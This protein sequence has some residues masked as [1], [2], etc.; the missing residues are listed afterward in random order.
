MVELIVLGLVIFTLLGFIAWREVFNK[1]VV[2]NLTDKLMARDFTE[3]RT[4]TQDFKT[5]KENK[6]EDGN[7][8]PVLDPVLGKHF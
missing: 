1:K 4:M 7:K 2:E 6:S 3:Y 8:K 5:K